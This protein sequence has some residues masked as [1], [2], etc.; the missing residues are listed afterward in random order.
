MLK[1]LRT[2]GGG[3]TPAML[4]V[5]LQTGYPDKRFGTWYK[6]IAG[7]QLRCSA[8]WGFYDYWSVAAELAARR[9][10]AAS[11]YNVPWWELGS[12]STLHSQEM[13][14]W[15]YGDI[16]QIHAVVESGQYVQWS[17][18]GDDFG[19]PIVPDFEWAN[20][21]LRCVVNIGSP[22]KSAWGTPEFGPV[23]VFEC[24]GFALCDVGGVT[25]HWEWETPDELHDF[26]HDKVEWQP[27]ILAPESYGRPAPVLLRPKPTIAAQP[28]AHQDITGI[29]RTGWHLIPMEV[30][31]EGDSISMYTDPTRIPW[32]ARL[33]GRALK[34]SRLHTDPATFSLVKVLD[35]SGDYRACDISGTGAVLWVT[36]VARA[37]PHTTHCWHSY[38]QGETWQGPVEVV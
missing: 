38:D 10:T 16:H 11:S 27:P 20:G 17:I 14:S 26:E 24:A 3:H 36:A 32:V 8:S 22:G 5:N 34:V 18:D 9:V 1:Y 29:Y 21:C 2:Y 31:Q 13:G 25:K 12:G 23:R 30:D 37:A 33:E 7:L 15:E 4:G 28:T 35:I 6:N 19:P